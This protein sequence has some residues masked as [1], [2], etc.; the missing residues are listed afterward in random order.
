MTHEFGAAVDIEPTSYTT[1][2]KTNAET[3]RML[4]SV[5]GTRILAR[6]DGTL[7]ALFESPFR[8]AR[9][10]GDNPSWV[11]DPLVGDVADAG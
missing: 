10:A 7:L 1:A 6:A 4:R 8:L 11:L 5:P 9:L 2:R 3:A